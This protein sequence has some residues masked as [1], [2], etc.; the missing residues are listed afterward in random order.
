MDDHVFDCLSVDDAL[1]SAGSSCLAVDGASKRNRWV[2]PVA[3]YAGAGGP[4]VA[5]HFNGAG[6]SQNSVEDAIVTTNHGIASQENSATD[7]FVIGVTLNVAGVLTYNYESA[8]TLAI[9]DANYTYAEVKR[10]NF[11]TVTATWTGSHT[12]TLLESQ[13][14]GGTFFLKNSTGQTMQLAVAGVNGDTI[15]DA[16]TK[17][18][19]WDG[20]TARAI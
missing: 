14:A 5:F 7:N 11:L 9:A 3:T 12:F 10:P 8:L 17:Q 16:A 6:T 20:T 13:F 18:L 1:Y 4:Q 15:A 19:R 2:R